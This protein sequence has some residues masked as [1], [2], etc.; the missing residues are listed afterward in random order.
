M[1]ESGDKLNITIIEAG[2]RYGGRMRI[3]DFVGTNVEMG[4]SWVTGTKGDFTN[5]VW[6]MV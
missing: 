2:D 3:E 4:A 1:V 6:K 5:P